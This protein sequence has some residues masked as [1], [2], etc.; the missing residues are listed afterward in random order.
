MMSEPRVEEDFACMDSYDH[1]VTVQWNRLKKTD[2][3]SFSENT[4]WFKGSNFG[5]NEAEDEVDSFRLN[6]FQTEKKHCLRNNNNRLLVAFPE[7]SFAIFEVS[8]KADENQTKFCM[9]RYKESNHRKDGIAVLFSV[10]AKNKK[11]LMYCAGDGEIHFKE[12]T[13]P[14]HIPS[15]KSE[16]IFYQK[17]FSCTDSSL[18]FES[19]IKPD[20]YLA[21]REENN[22]QRLVLKHCPAGCLNE[23]IRISF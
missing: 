11:Y 8:E 21:F 14:Q 4:L 23:T 9:H 6:K 16:Y 7:N 18:K 19:S 12:E 22:M 10:D 17:A 13:L 1:M 20:H 5:N 2:I 15:D 3:I